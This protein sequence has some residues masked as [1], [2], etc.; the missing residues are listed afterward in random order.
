MD[1]IGVA[2]LLAPSA[3]RR[4]PPVPRDDQP[5]GE[6]A[7]PRAICP[8]AS[9]SDRQSRQ[10]GRGNLVG[11]DQGGR[12]EKRNAAADEPLAPPLRV[13]LAHAP[14]LSERLRFFSP[15]G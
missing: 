13:R 15:P 10:R 5:T 8:G 6:A 3:Q 14:A 11:D 2:L 12:P 1:R 9:I 4:E 7:R